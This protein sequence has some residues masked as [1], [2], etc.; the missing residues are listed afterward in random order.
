[1]SSSI[2]SRCHSPQFLDYSTHGDRSEYAGMFLTLDSVFPNGAT[3]EQL[4]AIYRPRPGSAIHADDACRRRAPDPVDHVH[5]RTGRHRRV[6]SAGHPLS[7]RHPAD[8]GRQR[9]EADPPGCRGLRRQ[10]RR[11]QLLHDGRD[12]HLHP[13]VLRARTRLDCR[14]WWK[15]TRTTQLQIEIARHVDWV[16]DFALPPLVLH[17]LLHR[18]RRAARS[19]GSASGRPTR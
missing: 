5:V 10:A 7:R 12:L 6:T 8:P 1:M 18:Q 2:T 11:W 13:C 17:A 3:E 9:R 16:Y 14:C 4:L 15:S 19:T